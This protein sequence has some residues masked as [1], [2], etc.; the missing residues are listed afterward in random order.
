V[1]DGGGTMF[2]DDGAKALVDDDDGGAALQLR[3]VKGSEALV[4]MGDRK[5][6]SS[7]LT[8]G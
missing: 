1:A 8:M 4:E 2:L 7:K 3:G 6:W 5:Q